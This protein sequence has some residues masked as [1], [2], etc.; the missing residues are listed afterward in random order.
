MINDIKLALR[1]LFRS[2]GFTSAV[3]A[4]IAVGIGANVAVFT[5]LDALL[6]TPLPV[7]RPDRLVI[8]A[9]YLEGDTVASYGYPYPTFQ[10][11]CK[12][13]ERIA[14]LAGVS[15]IDRSLDGRSETIALVSGS[16]FSTLGVSAAMG[17]TL[18]QADDRVSGQQPTAA[19]SDAFARGRFGSPRAAVGRTVTLADTTYTIIGVMPPA[20]RGEWIGRPVAIWIPM[21][22]QSEV[23]RERPG[24]LTNPNPGWVH[25]VARLNDGVTMQRASAA[26]RS[27]TV[28]DIKRLVPTDRPMSPRERALIM[29]AHDGLESIV[30]GFA[31]Q[32]PRL[33][34]PFVVV[35]T[36][37][38]L[39]LVVTCFNV[40]SLQVV[41]AAAGERDIA[42][43]LALGATRGQVARERLVESVVLASLAG[44]TGVLVAMWST[45]ALAA[46][47]GASPIATVAG[48]VTTAIQLGISWR[49]IAFAFA[50]SVAAGTL[51]GAA[52]AIHAAQTALGHL[53]VG[54]S[55]ATRAKP[56]VVNALVSAQIAVSLVL[57]VAGG[58][59][60][61]TEENLK[62]QALG[63]D[64]DRVLLMWTAPS[65]AGLL[66]IPLARDYDRIGRDLAL[67]P[68]VER[69]S[70][71]SGGVLGNDD[72]ASP[73]T[74][75]GRAFGPD[76]D[77]W[78]RWNLVAPGFFDTVG[79]HLIAGRD[80]T[81]RDDAKAPR[82]AI[83]NE[84]M[85]RQYFGGL[86]IGK[87]FGLRRDPPDAIEI[88]GIVRDGRVDSLR[89]RP[90]P[91]AYL[92]YAQETDHVWSL[93]VAI[94]VARDA[95]SAV[96]QLLAA[97]RRID[98]NLPISSIEPVERQIHRALFAERLLAGAS[99]GFA[100]TAL[101]LI[102]LGLY[103]VVSYV[104]RRRTH[105]IGIR[106]AMGATR[107]AVMRLIL[108]QGAATAAVGFAA[109]IP[110]SLWAAR[111][112]AGHLY[113]VAPTD[114]LTLTLA[115]AALAAVALAACALP[116]RTAS[117]LDPLVA[118]RHE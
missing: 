81:A 111:L 62:T 65:H 53:R 19:I 37:V 58:L 110:A 117:M 5:V 12:D 39:V 51:L 25:I 94:R 64:R 49:S 116:A 104:G 105:E 14:T 78:L 40:A 80:F 66:G 114:P 52:P 16:Y 26:L 35:I 23:M 8:F 91:L 89:E 84:A 18:D 90:A 3:I 50:V 72:A 57:L 87:R 38:G 27:S 61:R 115:V 56:F 69:V 118:L 24:L 99:S 20:F 92:P 44:A 113:G 93:C 11:L 1:M 97:M 102:C 75:A 21:A 67:L 76:E 28:Q 9:R 83:V 15:E 73:M 108:R 82:V 10:R 109:G 46:L 98:P 32:R 101:L 68:G 7:S 79:M 36:G 43:R 13:L 47:V 29:Q 100:I 59:L 70:A 22:R 45:D 88:V 6:F 106:L 31:P 4:I 42:I 112:L 107:A 63:F 60:L 55:G 95:G 34:A 86:A 54:G 96:P 30:H 71:S 33:I 85:A 41:R 17:R 77:N 103:G 48:N 2:R 74:I